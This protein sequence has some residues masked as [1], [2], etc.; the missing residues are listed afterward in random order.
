M[1]PTTLNCYRLQRLLLVV[2]RVGEM[3]LAKWWNTRGQL[4]GLGSAAIMTIT[5]ELSTSFN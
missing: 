1:M 4:G 5:H 3:D 2:A